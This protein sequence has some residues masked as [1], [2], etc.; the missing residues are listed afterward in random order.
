VNLK[1]KE[2]PF[3]LPR[4]IAVAVLAVGA[5]H[6]GA[7]SV[8]WSQS[9]GISPF[10]RQWPRFTSLNYDMEYEHDVFSSAGA[11]IVTDRVYLFPSVGVAWQSY[12]Y[13][14]D[15]LAFGF[16][17]EPGYVWEKSGSPGAMSVTEQLALNGDFRADVLREK[18]YATILSYSS[19]YQQVNYDFFNTA[20]VD[21]QDWGVMSGYREGPVPVNLS[22]N[23]AYV[24][25][26][27]PGQTSDTVDTT[28]TLDTKNQRSF[29]DQTHLNYQ[30]GQFNR[31][32]TT[33]GVSFTD[34]NNYNLVT[35]SDIEHYQKSIWRSSLLF[36]QINTLNTF[37]SSDLNAL[38][39]YD[40]EHTPN[41][42]SIYDY[43]FS[44]YNDSI[45]ESIQNTASASVH[46]Q[47][48]DSLASSLGVQGSTL[49]SSSGDSTLDSYSV[50][51]TG[52]ADYTK[53]LGSWGRLTIGE[54]LSYTANDQVVSGSQ[55][56]IPNESHIV[57]ATGIVML[58]QPNAIEVVSVFYGNILLQEGIGGDYTINTASNPWQ[59][60]INVSG[61]PNR[62]PAGATIQVTYTVKPNPS[63]TYS[64]LGNQSKVTLSFFN[65][66]ADV[67]VGYNL[68]Q[69]Q[70]SSPDFLLQ[71]E[72]QFQTG[73]DFHWRGLSLS[74]NY[75]DTVSTLYDSRTY[76]LGENYTF[77][78]SARTRVGI[79]LNQQWDYYTYT[80]ALPGN[81]NQYSTFYNFMVFC[82][83][84]PTTHLSWNTE[85]GL[86]RAIG[87]QI[88]QNFIAVRSYLNWNIGKLEVHLGYSYEGQKFPS[89]RTES[90]Y[91]F[92]RFRRYF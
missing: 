39:D 36:N 54:G 23:Q 50:Q 44:W 80:T 2:I 47:L 8:D 24:N 20:L 27:S 43:A 15:L 31:Q 35:L 61:G 75:M 59:I 74:G 34:D 32:N 9:Q 66:L 58:D 86:Q 76:N 72:R 73:A 16:Q 4:W 41:L 85:A 51:T 84:R 64:T 63:G 81:E 55:T 11:H 48:Y 53:R 90:N 65:D 1:K 68:T 87:S 3:R 52:T 83:W 40:I 91:A 22:F 10:G 18:P 60:L 88:N 38:T 56:I 67:Y 89:Q 17:F 69:N 45:S 46:H 30:F 26:T 14:P 7:Q 70:A 49:N 62:V 82:D 71:D 13:H 29:D 25:S 6:A 28:V 92:I 33:A 37:S 12:L 42:H 79:N 77:N 21:S 5:S 19:S 57:P 78:P